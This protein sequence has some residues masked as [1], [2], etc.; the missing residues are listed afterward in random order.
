MAPQHDDRLDDGADLDEDAELELP[1][2]GT[3]DLHTFSPKELR[4]LI[5]D[6]LGE[7][8]VRGIFE[9]RIIHGKGT[10]ALRRSVH[11]LLERDPRVLRFRLAGADAGSWGATLV[12]LKRPCD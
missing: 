5:P 7:C 1:I 10:G 9:L 12:E 3:L 8:L 11:A 6:Y 2:D 4:T